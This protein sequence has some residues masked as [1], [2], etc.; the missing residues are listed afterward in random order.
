MQGATNLPETRH[1]RVPT[2]ER[3]ASDVKVGRDRGNTGSKCKSNGFEAGRDRGNTGSKCK[4]NGF[5]AN[6]RT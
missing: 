1:A 5:E 3:K 6:N 4:P 2:W